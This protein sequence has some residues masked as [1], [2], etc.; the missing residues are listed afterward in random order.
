MK[1]RSSTKLAFILITVVTLIIASVGAVIAL[2]SSSNDDNQRFITPRLGPEGQSYPFRNRAWEPEQIQE[3]TNILNRDALL[4]AT[5]NQ[6]GIAVLD[7]QEA[8][9]GA[10]DQLLAEAVD[11]GIITQDQADSFSPWP[12]DP[13]RLHPTYGRPGFHE[14]NMRPYLES[15]L[16][17]EVLVEKTAALLDIP[18]TDLQTAWE[19]GSLQDLLDEHETDYQSLRKAMLSARDQIIAEAVAAGTLTQEDA[20]R[21]QTGARGSFRPHRHGLGFYRFPDRD[22]DSVPNS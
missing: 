5:A 2:E 15:V 20:D 18:A 7:L 21:L 9:Q 3:V 8:L 13:W 6:L 10:M 19:N 11:T 14:S 17:E 16:D 12:T 1:T 4:A 22:S